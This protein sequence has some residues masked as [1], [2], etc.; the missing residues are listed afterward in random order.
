L[1]NRRKLFSD[2]VLPNMDS[3]YRL[4]RGL[5]GNTSDAEDVIQDACL[6]A[7]QS[8]E[9][10]SGGNARAWLMTITRNVAFTFLA[11]RRSLGLVLSGDQPEAERVM[12]L[13]PD[14]RATPEA[15]VIA[16]AEAAALEAA[17]AQLPA[18]YREA[19]VLREFNELSYKEIAEL[20]GVP[21][22]TVMSRLARARTELLKLLWPNAGIEP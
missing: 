6:R 1:I 16:K 10:Y 12:D 2:L 13:E 7:F 18:V 14:P 5:T 11:R 21:L 4:A 3:A 15:T 22:G 19:L 8:L 20:T 17:I 9:Y